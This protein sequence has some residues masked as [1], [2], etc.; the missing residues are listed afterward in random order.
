MGTACTSNSL[1]ADLLQVYSQQAR[2]QVPVLAFPEVQQL[3]HAS[4]HTRKQA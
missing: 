4:K 2:C 3:L 1:L